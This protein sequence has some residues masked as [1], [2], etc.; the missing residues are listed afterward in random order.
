MKIKDLIEG[1]PTSIKLL[2]T[3]NKVKKAKT[4]NDY[5]ETILFDGDDK[6]LGR[7]FN[8]DGTPSNGSEVVVDVEGTL[9]VFNH[10]KYF[11]ISYIQLSSNQDKTMF[12]PQPKVD[13]QNIKK[14]LNKLFLS[15][16]N[17]KYVKIIN[18]L[19]KNYDKDFFKRPAAKSNHHDYLGGLAY[20]TVS[21]MEIADM[22][23]KYYQ[24]IDRSLL[25]TG[26]FLHDFGKIFELTDK[27]N[28]E[29][30]VQGEL[31]GHTEI[32]E[33]LVDE[34]CLR[35]GISLNDNDVI[36]LKH[37][38]LSH[39]GTRKCG[40]SVEPMVIEAEILHRLDG[41]DATINEINK[42]LD[43][44]EKD[45]FTDKIFALNNRKFLKH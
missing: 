24:G 13:V 42:A 36:L 37:V 35:Q 10:Q 4:G 11:K 3:N 14:R 16:T 38:I 43:K 17:Q 45:E 30:S 25:F 34:A 8:Y 44:T 21:I 20:H 29:Y 41:L 40:A 12:M 7:Y 28:T 31:L 19:L 18:Y 23:T 33:D 32:C 39:H 27:I 15:V 9:A 5:L 1:K 2:A 26:I 22:I 6:I